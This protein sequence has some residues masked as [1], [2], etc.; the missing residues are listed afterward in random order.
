MSRPSDLS[1]LAR[2]AARLARTAAARN[3]RLP[4]L[5]ILTDPSRTPDPIA[6]AERLPEGTGLIYRAFGAAEARSTAGA[7]A[8]IARRRGLTLLIGADAR[9]ARACGAQGV[10]LPERLLADAP[11]LRAGWPDALV[12]GAAHN[13]RSIRRARSFRLDA[14][15]VSTVFE[16]I[17]P[18]AGKPIGTIRLAG[19]MWL[20]DGLPI[21][22]L[23][24]ITAATA[25]RL[26]GTGVAGVAAV[27]A[28][29]SAR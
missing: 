26:S 22:A 17:S 24:G 5:L 7:L 1:A 4:P 28:A 12:T 15:L 20:A 8:H 29:L 23:G 25:V 16:S 19:R 11:R 14:A 27:G 3:A 18:S 21:Y 9:L 2:A 10:H 13:V 6:L